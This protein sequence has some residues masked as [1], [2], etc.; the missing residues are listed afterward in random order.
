MEG[1]KPKGNDKER[2]FNL[3]WLDSSYFET[4]FPGTPWQNVTAFF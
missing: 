2:P 3:A 4:L 1:N